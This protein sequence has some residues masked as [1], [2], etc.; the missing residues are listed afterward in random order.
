MREP[1]VGMTAREIGALYGVARFRV[2]YVSNGQPS[3]REVYKVG[4]G[5]FIGLTFV[6]GVV[7]EFET[8]GGMPDDASFQGL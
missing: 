4:K 8:L 3:S 6:D 5:A 2:E 7:T 1:R